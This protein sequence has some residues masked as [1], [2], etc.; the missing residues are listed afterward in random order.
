[1][2]GVI[3][4]GCCTA[5]AGLDRPIVTNGNSF[6]TDRTFVPILLLAL[7]GPPLTAQREWA[8]REVV[9]WAAKD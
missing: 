7:L 2:I 9:R 4:A 6:R 1:M 8:E 5:F 3:V